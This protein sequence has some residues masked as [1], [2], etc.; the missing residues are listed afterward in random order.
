[1]S[2]FDVSNVSKKDEDVLEK[3][4]IMLVDDEIENLNVLRRLLES[5]F[6]II[7]GGDGK[8]ALKLIDEMSD[9]TTIQLIISDQR[10]PE[11][12]GV[13]FLEKIVDRMPHTIRIILT[14]YSDTQVIIDSINKAKLYKFI[15]KPFD[16]VELSL[17][18]QR[19]AE[20]FQMRQEL[21]AYSNNL[22]KLVEQRTN[23]LQHKNIELSE[24][25][26]SL[27]KLSLIDQLTQLHNR[28]FLHKLMKQ[29]LLKLKREAHS[30][31]TEESYF[32]LVLVDIDFFKRVNDTY[33]HEAGDNVLIQF[34]RI[35][36][37]TCR[38]SD[39]VVRWGGEEFLIVARGL[40]SNGL[41]NLAE[42]IR[43]NV[44]SSNFDLNDKQ[45][46]S[47]TCSLGT[48]YFPL[49]S[50]SM[51]TLTW[52]QTLNI[53]DLALYSAKNSGRNTWVSFYEGTNFINENLH[54]N[55]TSDLQLAI[56]NG[57][58]E[59]SSSQNKEDVKL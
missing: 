12:S 48:A 13:E 58:V 2:I 47:I 34:S 15:T 14:G 38:E 46:I 57:L 7:T 26:E 54:E 29:E 43:S 19:G 16:P 10:M 5:K 50:E 21:I 42:R 24:A 31:S 27:E 3:P 59:F 39:W 18:V 22:E 53:A 35:L 52:E 33:G 41:Q 1:M 9:P 36:Q 44:G 20:A 23:E 45:A 40:T 17:T 49:T 4:L 8:E 11:M 25:L 32:G 28:H 37:D 55:V 6:Q 51:G 56:D 30:C